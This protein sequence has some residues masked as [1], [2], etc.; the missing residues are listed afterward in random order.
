MPADARSASPTIR[1]ES[2]LV[3]PVS[4]GGSALV[5]DY[6]EGLPKALAFYPG[7]PYDLDSFRHKLAEVTARFG[8]DERA[9]AARSL[10]PTSETARER[11]DHFVEK[12]GAVVT[13]GQQ[14]GFLTGPL[15]T[16]YKALAGVAL[17]RHLERQLGTPVIPVFWVASDDHDWLEVNHATL[18]DAQNRAR[19]YTLAS[20]DDRPLPM[21]DRRLA[22]D[23]ETLLDEISQV[24]AG[25]ES[26]ND[27]IKRILK[28]YRSADRTVAAAFGE[29]MATI[30]EP[31]DACLADAASPELKAI[32]RPAIRRALVD[33]QS[34]ETVLADRSERLL[35][36]GYRSQVAVL[37]R[38]T[39]VFYHG[40]GGRERLY[41]RGEDFTVRGGGD[42]LRRTDLL[43]ELD[44]HPERFSPNVLLRP[45]VESWVYPTLAYV[46][47]PAELAYLAQVNALFGAYEIAPPVAVPRFSGW[48]VEPKVERLLNRLDLQL[49]DALVPREELIDRLARREIPGEVRSALNEIRRDL[50]RDYDQLLD[51]ATQLDA[52]LAGA[53]GA[54]RNRALAEAA[55][56]ERKVIRAIKKGDR[57]AVHQLDRVL[58]S[59]RPGGKPQDRVLNVLPFL[60]RYGDHLLREI[61]RAIERSWRLPT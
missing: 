35:D 40:A 33:A 18:L 8:R 34:H 50:A 14:A 7:S 51:Q 41:R 39:N 24:I 44:A 31:F 30:L 25:N 9:A 46:G 54:S 53:V 42:V 4:V 5:R 28:P 48:I 11:L 58:D 15:Y 43:E 12:G 23:L 49:E 29:A 37:E 56:M 21:S 27:Y 17:A 32:A 61:E 38:G 26:T 10:R 52:T 20:D 13:T 6:L 60:A 57:I 19:R 59:L 1:R 2:G 45:V 47:G 3:R 16:I 22:E 36:G 55:R